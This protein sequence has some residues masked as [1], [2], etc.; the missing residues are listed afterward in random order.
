MSIY[1]K[2]NVPTESSGDVK[3]IPEQP[4]SE[5]IH[6]HIHDHSVHKDS[7]DLWTL[8]ELLLKER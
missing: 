1:S 2:L 3:E 7:W 5:S 8:G 6:D 4:A